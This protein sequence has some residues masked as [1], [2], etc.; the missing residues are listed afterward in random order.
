MLA[1]DVSG[2]YEDT[3][4]R[5]FFNRKETILKKIPLIDNDSLDM[6]DKLY[7]PLSRLSNMGNLKTGENH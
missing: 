6:Q 3:L 7:Y 5:F 4:E 1:K 2:I